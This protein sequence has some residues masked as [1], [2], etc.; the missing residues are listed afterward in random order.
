MF[1]QVGVEPVV[2]RIGAYK[3]AGDTINRRNST[4]EF[5]E[6]QS[7]LVN[8]TADFW[9]DSVARDL[10]K[11]KEEILTL[12]E[13]PITDPV[14]LAYRKY[15]TVRVKYGKIINSRCPAVVPFHRFF[16]SERPMPGP[17][18]KVL[19][20][21]HPC[22]AQASLY[23][24]QVKEMVSA[25]NRG[26]RFPWSW[27]ERP[28]RLFS[29]RAFLK[30]VGRG[31]NI[32]PGLPGVRGPTIAVINAGGE[33]S[34][35]GA[36]NAKGL[37]E[38][39]EQAEMDRR[40]KAVVLRVDSPGGDALTSELI[41]RRILKLRSVKPVV[42][43][44][45]DVAASGGYFLSMGCSAI[46]AEDTTITGSIGVVAVLFKLRQLYEKIGLNEEA[47]GIGKYSKFF[48]PGHLPTEEERAYFETDVASSYQDFVQ[49]AAFCRNM[50]W[51][52][53]HAVAQGRV[54]KGEDAR[55][56]GLVDAEGGLWRALEVA[57]RMA[58]IPDSRDVRLRTI[59]GT[60]RLFG[61]GRSS[62]EED[63]R[64]PSSLTKLS[65]GRPLALADDAVVDYMR[66]IGGVVPGT[67]PWTQELG[68]I[69][70][71]AL[72]QLLA[73]LF[74]SLDQEVR[75]RNPFFDFFP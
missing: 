6:V 4:E 37:V 33:I 47:F 11:P 8:Q 22:H 64:A 30:A 25:R 40:V 67:Q 49:K 14:R 24:D 63:V 69:G 46:V 19:I 32:L 72:Q 23:Y 39:L 75:R 29:M 9:L 43:S 66:M 55:R 38:L 68:L 65:M 12:W 7:L 21:L 61:G 35:N 15:I 31:R 59:R 20:N 48:V 56:L 13:D 18:V 42:A 26:R 52:Q 27:K 41:W 54:W 28:A 71:L 44:M 45:V 5:R 57:K 51:D 36:I 2:V 10:Q 70:G 73:P 34:Q 17:R 53:A 58:K 60:R 50:T 16:F 3:G 1:D 62:E 74:L